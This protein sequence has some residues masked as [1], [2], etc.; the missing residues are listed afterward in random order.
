MSYLCKKSF[1]CWNVMVSPLQKTKITSTYRLWEENYTMGN[2]NFLEMRLKISL[3]NI[4]QIK[5]KKNKV[6]RDPFL[7]SLP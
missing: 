1:K 6:D 4:L 5:E 2:I 3:F 7:T